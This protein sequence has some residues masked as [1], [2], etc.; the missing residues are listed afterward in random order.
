MNVRELLPAG[1]LLA[2]HRPSNRQTG[3][4]Y[5]IR[6]QAGQDRA[7][8]DLYDAI[9]WDPTPAEF[10]RDLRDIDAPIIELHIN[11]PGGFVFD[12]LTIY[13]ALVDHPARVEAVV[14]GL[15][16]SAASWIFQAGD[17]RT[18]N[19]HTQLFIHDGLM[20]T[21]GNEADHL[22]SATTLGRISNELAAIYAER[23]AGSVAAWRDAMRAETWYS[24]QEAVDVGLADDMVTDDEQADNYSDRAR[25]VTARARAHHLE[26]TA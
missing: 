2:H 17:T 12:G 7:R 15:A 10:V 22:D 8:V 13:N 19:R 24:A 18:M 4:W 16:A 5:E 26:R 20:L 11:S 1:V 3:G 6:G 23:G 21:I 9:G 14:D 25:L